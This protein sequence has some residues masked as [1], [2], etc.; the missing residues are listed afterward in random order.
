MRGGGGRNEGGT[1]AVRT[2][3]RDIVGRSL[4]SSSASLSVGSVHGLVMFHGMFA[5]H[6]V[7]LCALSAAVSACS[8]SLELHISSSGYSAC[9]TLV[10]AR[11]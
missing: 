11:K 3:V 1:L 2:P 6:A 7:R 9:S 8:L 5:P 4:D 10:A